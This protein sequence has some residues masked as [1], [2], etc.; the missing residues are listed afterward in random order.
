MQETLASTLNSQTIYSGRVFTVVSEQVQLPNGRKSTMDVVRHQSSVILIPMPDPEHVVLVRQYR[1][2]INSWI[3]EL[4]AGMLEPNEDAKTAARREC[5]EETGQVPAVVEEIGTFY[6]TPGYCDEKMIF[7]KLTQL[8]SPTEP[9]QPDDDEIL[10]P[11]VFTIDEALQII[12]ATEVI[13]MKTA[14]GLKLI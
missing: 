5:E 8:T 14:L 13:D 1:H 9:A 2:S 7:F 12:H 4:P 11:R 6:P 10:E 3:W